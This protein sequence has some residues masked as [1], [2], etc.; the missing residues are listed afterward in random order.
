MELTQEA[1]LIK[2]S[3]PNYAKEKQAAIKAFAKA[4]ADEIFPPKLATPQRMAAVI[5]YIEEHRA[6]SVADALNLY[7]FEQ[8]Q[9]QQAA[10]QRAHNARVS[11]SLCVRL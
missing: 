1:Q 5:S 2:N 8:R 11:G 9:Q 10:E 4:N 7:I 3:L 6:N